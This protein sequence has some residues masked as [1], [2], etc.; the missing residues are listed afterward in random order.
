[1]VG[2]CIY[3]YVCVCIYIYIYTYLYTC[4]QAKKFLNVGGIFAVCGALVTSTLNQM[5][6]QSPGVYIRLTFCILCLHWVESQV[7]VCVYLLTCVMIA[8]MCHDRWHVSWSHSN[9]I[10]EGASHTFLKSF[11][12]SISKFDPPL[13]RTS[14]D[15]ILAV[16]IAPDTDSH[17][18]KPDSNGSEN[19]HSYTSQE[20]S[21]MHS[22][23]GLSGSDLHSCMPGGP[24]N[25]RMEL[26][27]ALLSGAVSTCSQL[28]VDVIIHGQARVLC[29]AAS[30]DWGFQHTLSYLFGVNPISW[31]RT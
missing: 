21:H 11:L 17:S 27:K 22:N 31:P 8:D 28:I 19:G 2:V 6:R 5:Q 3:I 24:G 16:I 15:I 29:I 18:T 13:P 4:M 25:A 12:P 26:F 7:H 10:D 20:Y 9:R 14:F 30:L 1:M 23:R